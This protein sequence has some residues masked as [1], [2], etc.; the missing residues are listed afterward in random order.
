MQFS[1]R[2]EARKHVEAKQVGSELFILDLS[3]GSYFGLDEIGA[4]V[5]QGIAAQKCFGEICETVCAEYDVKHE[6]AE[7]DIRALLQQLSDA[8]LIDLT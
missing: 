7:R 2:I 3:K 8:S 1:T 6:I 4:V 5:W